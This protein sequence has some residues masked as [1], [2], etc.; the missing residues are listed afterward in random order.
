MMNMNAKDFG[1]SQ[2]IRRMDFP[3][4]MNRI[5]VSKSLSQLSSPD[6]QG[7]CILSN[8]E[9]SRLHPNFHFRW[10]EKKQDISGEY[11]SHGG[12]KNGI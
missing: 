4:E 10:I 8:N 6:N 5:S 1:Q 7:R 12:I 2:E 11:H 3:R 9:F